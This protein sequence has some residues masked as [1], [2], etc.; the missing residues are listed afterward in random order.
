MNKLFFCLCLAAMVT[1]VNAQKTKRQPLQIGDTVP[2]VFFGEC[3]QGKFAVKSLADCRG[4]LTILDFWDTGC[5]GCILGMP[6]MDSLQQIFGDRIQTIIICYNHRK[7]VEGM[8]NR[9]RKPLP[10]TPIIL[11]DSILNAYFPHV[12]VPHHVWIDGAGVVK[13][14]TYDH[15]ATVDNVRRF[16]N[17]ETLH[18]ALK[19]EIT[20]F[21]DNAVLYAEGNGRWNREIKYHTLF[22]TY[23]DGVELSIPQLMYD[24]ST[25]S[26]TLRVV[27]H[28]YRQLFMFAYNRDIGYGLYYQKSRWVLET[29][30]RANFF[31]GTEVDSLIDNWNKKKLAS[32][33]AVLPGKDP[34]MLFTAMQRDLNIFSPYNARIEKRKVKCLLLVNK[35]IKPSAYK[36]TDSVYVS[37]V[38]DSWVAKNYTIQNTVFSGMVEGNHDLDTPIL[39]ETHYTGKTDLHF[40]GSLSNLSDPTNFVRAQEDLRKNGLDLE[41]GYRDIDMLVIRDKK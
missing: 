22:A 11:E 4:R 35:G 29:K 7:D 15:N 10:S 37:E 24:P 17:G 5:L 23:L 12:T 38:N 8:F 34:A 39:D 26:Q 13:F 27:N 19:K 36:G 18:F 20:D 31:N 40:A 16:L 28:F 9:I 30:D 14:I 25:N 3:L 1:S 6:H 32:Y 33:E 2:N 21:D 41:Y